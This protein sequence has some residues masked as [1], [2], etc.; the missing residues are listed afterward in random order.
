MKPL[1]RIIMDQ[2][3]INEA[4]EAEIKK[5]FGRLDI[6]SPE[7]EEYK[8]ILENIKT[9]NAIQKEFNPPA[10]KLPKEAVF[11]GAV[12]LIGIFGM[13]AFEQ[14]GHVISTKALGFISKMKV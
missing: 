7:D 3:S 10:E 1:E 13:L 8:T 11:A 4:Y 6:I 12:N 2:S 9:L 5:A 14:Y